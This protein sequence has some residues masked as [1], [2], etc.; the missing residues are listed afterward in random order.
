MRKHFG[1][2]QLEK[3]RTLKNDED[4]PV[5]NNFRDVQQTNERT[6]Y[7]NTY[8]ADLPFFLFEFADSAM[9]TDA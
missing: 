4:A 3:F 8:A 1:S 6:V 9:Y 2:L 7:R 5:V